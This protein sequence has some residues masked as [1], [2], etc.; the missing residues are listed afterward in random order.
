MLFRSIAALANQT[1]AS[2]FVA[3]AL[4]GLAGAWL[5][6]SLNTLRSAAPVLSH[7]V[8][9]ALAGAIVAVEIWKWRM[10]IRQSTGV[11]F[12]LPIAVGIAIG[13]WGCLFAG[14]ADRTYGFPSTLP[15]AV[16]PGDGIARAPVQIYESISM[17]LFALFFFLVLRSGKSW[18]WRTGFQW[19][20]IFY[21]A[22]RFLWEY[23]KPYPPLL[24]G[25]N[26]FHFLMLG[27]IAYGLLWIGRGTEAGRRGA[28]G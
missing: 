24:F 26:V 19:L 5:F 1:S 28:R 27:L 18:P 16:D 4:G 12:V 6:G 22:Q 13:R 2:Y 20:V 7:S 11:P 9:G 15:W 3:L 21:A 14:P 10:G 23:Q 25:L 17:A 8:A